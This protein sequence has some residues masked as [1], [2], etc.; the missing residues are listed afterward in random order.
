[1]CNVREINNSAKQGDIVHW[2]KKINNLISII[3]NRFDGVRV[4]TSDVDS[5]YLTCYVCKVSEVPGQIFCVRLLFKNKLSVSILG[6]YAGA[7]LVV[8]FS[9]AGDINFFIAKAINESSFVILNSDF[10]EDGFRKC[11]SF[12]KCFDLGLVNSLAGSA[13]AKIPIWCN[14]C[15]IAK[16]ID[17]VFVSSNLVNAM[18]GHSVAGVVNYFDTDHAAVSVFVS[19]GGL[20]D[21]YNVKGVNE[22]KWC[23]FRNAIAANVAVF[24]SIFKMAERF[25]D[26]DAMWN[27]IHGIMCSLADKTFKRKW[28]KDYDSVFTKVSF[29]FHKLELLVFRLVKAFHLVLSDD[30]VS[31]LGTW[32]GLNSG[33]AA[34]VKSLFFSGSTFDAICSGL[35][36]VWKFYCSFKFLEFKYAEESCI[37]QTIA[38]RIKS[39]KLD[40]DRTIRSVLEHPFCK[41][42]LDHLVVDNELVLEPNLVKSK[43]DEIMKSWTRKRRWKDVLTN[44]H[45]IVLIEAAHKIFFKILSDRISSAC[46]TYDVLHGDNFSVLK[47]TTTQLLIF[48]ISLVI[49]DALEKNHELWLVLQDMHKAYDSVNW[50]HLRKSLVRIKMCDRFIRFF[51][52]IHNGQV[53]RVMTDF[54]LTDGGLKSK[55]GL[56]DDFS[57]DAIHH[58]FLYGLKTFEQIQAESKSAFI[59]FLRIFWVFWVLSWCFRHP[60]QFPVCIRVNS[61]NNFLAG[62]VHIFSGCDLSLG[63]SLTS[64]FHYWGCTPMSLVLKEPSY[65]KCVSSLR[66]YGVAFLSVHFLGGGISPSVCSL[67][68]D[69]FFDVLQS[70]DFG[71]IGIELLHVNAACLFVYTDG[72]LNNLSTSN[73]MAGAAVFFEDIDLG[74]GVGVLS[75]VSSTMMELQAIALALECIPPSHFVNLFSDSQ[76]VLNTCKSES[77]LAYPDFRNQCWVKCH[78]IVNVIC[79]KN[80]DVNWIK[81]RGHS[82]VPGNECADALARTATFFDKCLSYMINEQFLQTNGTIVFGNSW[83]FIHDIFQFIHYSCWEVGSSFHILADSLHADIDWSRSFLVWY[84]DSHLAAGFTNAHT[85]GLHS[86]FI[87]ALYCRLLVVVCKWLYNKCYPN[88]VCLFCGNVKVLDHVFSCPFDV[89]DHAHLMEAH[90][91]A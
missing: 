61:S 41:V 80:L 47:S 52:N 64:A 6:L 1:M 86:Y 43:V 36:R 40:K 77:V 19:L 3:I 59:I 85:A 79:C 76:T 45:P 4:F 8:R 16:M 12:K 22:K 2:H 20:L 21:K 74:L 46:S 17:Y 62:V 90:A 14:S 42:V 58:P 29:K 55:S 26:L 38:N 69:V 82:G 54:G 25:L 50:E 18:V 15:G 56:L 71:V 88:V 75:L 57:T 81:V 5:S 83:Y 68:L 23:K 84:S 31:L 78:H 28:F 30:F 44:T 24:S 70:L 32:N 63:S 48:A 67:L 10:N 9:Q 51:G 72:S 35:A 34:E 7:S 33:G 37:R 13:F 89:A 27:I 11:A 49:K 87:K 91:L 66:Q 53:N 73:M 65:F 60:L 39:F